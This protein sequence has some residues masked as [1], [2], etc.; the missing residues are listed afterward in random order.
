MGKMLQ[1]GTNEPILNI[2]IPCIICKN[3]SIFVGISVNF[4]QQTTMQ[5]N[6]NI[7]GKLLVLL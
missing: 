6:P 4:T 2:A 7:M 1:L 5:S 3:I